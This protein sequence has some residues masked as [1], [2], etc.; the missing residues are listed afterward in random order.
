MSDFQPQSHRPPVPP[1]DAAAAPTP[2]VTFPG[3]TP[4]RLAR[5][6]IDTWEGRLEFWDA[7]AETAWVA[8]PVT[9]YHERPSRRLA[10]LPNEL[11]QD[12]YER[13]GGAGMTV[14]RGVN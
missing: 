9:P 10:A 5:S 13:S 7:A 2:P 1:R 14:R 8:E 4:R 3:C 6:E 12:Y 11:I